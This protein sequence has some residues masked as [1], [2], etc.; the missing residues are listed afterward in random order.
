MIGG[1][2][3]LCEKKLTRLY[4]CQILS[5]RVKGKIS[6]R[7]KENRGEGNLEG[8]DDLECGGER[9]T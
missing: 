4:M 6:K 7:E 1:Y 9:E 8:E 3:M 5:K 2:V